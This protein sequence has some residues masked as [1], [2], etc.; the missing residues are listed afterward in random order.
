MEKRFFWNNMNNSIDAIV[1]VYN[2]QN[3]IAKTL[4]SLLSQPT[5]FKEI[6]IVDDGSI[7]HSAK[8]VKKFADKHKNIKYIFQNNQGVV[9]SLNAGLRMTNTNFVA[10]LDGDI[11]FDKD[12]LPKLIP[13]F[14]NEE[15]AAVS[16]LTKTM[17]PKNL[18]A[19]L[20]GY[21]VEYRQSK[22]K[23]ESVDHLSTTNVIYRKSVL[24]KIG[25]FDPEFRYGQ[26][27][28]MSY[29]IIAAGYKLI[30]SQKT[31]CLHFWPESFTGFMKQRMH[32]ALA[33][34]ML[35]KKYPKRLTGDKVSSLRYF[36]ELPLGLVFLLSLI[37]VLFYLDFLIV[38]G[39]VVML[40]YI[41]QFNEINFFIKNKKA[42]IGI[43]MPVFIALRTIA[44]LSGI[45]KFLFE[46]K[47][48][49]IEKF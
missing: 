8:I 1:T 49:T 37:S 33:R 48:S 29:R 46:M 35:I 38:V 6:I 23:S 17:N 7:D 10:V 2:K 25:L 26:D 22:I 11:S 34:A 13:Y 44:W 5:E 19:A 24:D 43:F 40:I 15:I 9:K 12:W 20:A 42:F 30:L 45:I 16:G 27:N 3:T 14:G 4:E 32:G 47:I 21:N 28:E 18:W 39:F 36:L 31:F 41:F